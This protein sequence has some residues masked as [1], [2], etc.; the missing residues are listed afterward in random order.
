MYVELNNGF[1]C[2]GLFCC[3]VGFLLL[4]LLRGRHTNASNTSLT[5]TF[6]AEA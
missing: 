3:V 6:D 1:V 4:N 2:V 5:E